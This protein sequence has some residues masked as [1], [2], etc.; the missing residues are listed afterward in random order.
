MFD[1]TSHRKFINCGCVVAVV[2]VDVERTMKHRG[3]SFGTSNNKSQK[4]LPRPLTFL[5]VYL[6]RT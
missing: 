1:T 5:E 6:A 3:S 4:Q 2:V